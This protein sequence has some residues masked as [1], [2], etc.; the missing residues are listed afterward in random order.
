MKVIR[1]LSGRKQRLLVTIVCG[2]AFSLFGYD[3]ALFGGVASGD[4]FVKQFDHP[5]PSLT[6][7]IAALYDIGCLVGSLVSI[8][9]CQR[10]GH[11]KLILGGSA[12]TILGAIIQTA[13]MNVGMLIG[14]RIIAGIGNGMNTATVPV[15][16]AETSL[17]ASRGRAVI[18][19]LFVNNVGW[20]VAQFLTLGFS[21]INSGIQWRIPTAFQIVFLVPIFFIL[22]FLPDSPRWLA[23]HERFEEAS[24][25]LSHIMEEDPS[26]PSFASQMQAIQEIVLVEGSAHKSKISELWTG[27]GR[28]LFRLLLACSVQLMAQIGGI[29]IFAYFVVI[30][31]QTQLGLSSTLSRALAACA[32]I[33]LL[34][35]NLTS[36]TVIEKW[37]R[38]RLL[39]LGSSGQCICFLVSAIV[40]STGGTATWAGIVV[41]VMV[42]LF[43]I[44][45]AFAWQSI[46]FLY[47]AEI[48]SLKYRARFYGL[49]NG[50]NWAINYVIVLITPIGISEIGWRLY[51]I[52]AVFNFVNGLVVYFFFVETARSS[53]EE[54]DLFFIGSD[55]VSIKPPPFL[56]L[57]GTLACSDHAMT[58]AT[59]LDK[60]TSDI[61]HLENVPQK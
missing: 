45:F 7:Q 59:E 57:T 37:G 60:H 5:S 16:H 27:Q 22:P 54:L 24:K 20:L 17:S 42:Y 10:F 47:P 21:F 18:G 55:R 14:G 3:Q 51:V 9:F 53:L 56:R 41:V 38:R 34:V 31:F 58:T 33:G 19:E 30:I 43:F 29:N 6:G 1:S 44:V 26:S 32:G 52:F 15:Y 49:S 11:R 50:C 35:S 39:L 13:S 46:P 25:V 40:L 12:I 2:C 28:N 48:L 61:M 23:S 36:I 4:A 8:I